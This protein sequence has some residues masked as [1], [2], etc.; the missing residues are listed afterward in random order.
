MKSMLSATV[1]H[2]FLLL[3]ISILMASDS[4][5]VK[6][7]TNSTPPNLINTIWKIPNVDFDT[8]LGPATSTCLYYFQKDGKVSRREMAML[9]SQLQAIPNYQNPMFNP[10]VNA[11]IEGGNPSS[12]NSPNRMVLS[13]TPDM[14]IQIDEVGIYKVIGSSIIMD[15]SGNCANC[16]PHSITARIQNNQ[17]EGE[18]LNKRANEKST[19]K[20]VKM[21]KVVDQKAQTTVNESLS[22]KGNSPSKSPIYT[23]NGI[24]DSQALLRLPPPNV[25]QNADGTYRPANG[26]RWINPNDPKDFRVERIP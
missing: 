16:H 8:A 23:G 3:V 24:S 9:Q 11:W 14:L 1:Q 2:S 7:Q 19:F 18:Y 25:V 10:Q 26:Y 15:F 17:M 12:V 22:N 21:P 6:A 13:S 5:V 20:I 4:S